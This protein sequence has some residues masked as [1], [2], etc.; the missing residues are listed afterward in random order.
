MKKRNLRWY[1]KEENLKAFMSLLEDL[2]IEKQCEIAIDM[3]IKASNYTDKDY[4]KVIDEIS[5]F[6]PSEYKRWYDVNPN[7]HV[8]IETLRD[9]NEQ[10]RLCVIKEF[11]DEILK[12]HSDI[13]IG[14]L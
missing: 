5:S 10:D 6:N 12:Q 9:L 7:I 13:D 14:E 11:Y 8:A 1:E 2:S 3:I 4:S